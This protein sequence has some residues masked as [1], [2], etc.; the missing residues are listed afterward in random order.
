VCDR[1][2]LPPRL[3]VDLSISAI[4][5]KEQY[6]YVSHEDITLIL[7]VLNQY[8]VSLPLLVKVWR[9][10]SHLLNQVTDRESIF[11]LLKYYVGLSNR[12]SSKML[13][14]DMEQA[15]SYSLPP[16]L[17]A[18][19]TQNFTILA[20]PKVGLQQNRSE[21]FR[22]SESYSSDITCASV[23]LGGYFFSTQRCRTQRFDGQIKCTCEQ[24]SV[25][26][27]GRFIT[28]EDLQPFEYIKPQE[29]GFRS[30]PEI[31]FSLTYLVILWCGTYYSNKL[32]GTHNGH[33]EEKLTYHP[34]Y[35]IY[36]LNQC[37]IPRAIRLHLLMMTYAIQLAVEAS[38][39][40]KVH[41]LLV[42]GLGI[43]ISTP[44]SYLAGILARR[45]ASS[46]VGTQGRF[47]MCA[48]IEILILIS[49]GYYAVNGDFLT[50]TGMLA[51]MECFFAGFFLDTL[52]LDVLF[53]LAAGGSPQIAQVIKLRGFY[54]GDVDSQPFFEEHS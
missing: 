41:Y 40:A 18:S 23:N 25:I 30:Y 9:S 53:M 10:L 43:L 35:S 22:V 54:Y 52:T 19:K 27:V 13:K 15:G 34:F 50:N 21:V 1:I 48:M 45:Y 42:I 37:D 2:D 46:K 51:L 39:V 38:L 28:F 8:E 3:L 5:S 14:S 26:A 33:I 24:S 7:R 44:F 4:E 6:P 12:L 49:L 47:L 20:D 17:F 36:A 29:D 16:M 11:P 32:E 31:F